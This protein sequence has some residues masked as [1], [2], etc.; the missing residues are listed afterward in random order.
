MERRKPIDTRFL[1][2][3]LLAG[4]V[5]W[6]VQLQAVYALSAW[7]TERD[8][9][10]ALHLV[11]LLCVAATLGGGLLAW[12]AWRAVGGWP[13]GAEAPAVGRTRYLAVLGV[14]TGGLFVIVIVAQWLAVVILPHTQGAG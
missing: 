8:R 14:M 1:W 7:A 10:A 6:V 4:P 11:S 12:R 3:G 13:T 5:A 2:A 9:P